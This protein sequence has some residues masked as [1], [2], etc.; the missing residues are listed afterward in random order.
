M[1]TIADCRECCQYIVEADQLN[2][3]VEKRSQINFF[4]VE[5]DRLMLEMKVLTYTFERFCKR[6]GQPNQMVFNSCTHKNT[7]LTFGLTPLE[8]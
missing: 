4:E 6:T 2:P 1:R 3:A 5:I 7:S 8:V